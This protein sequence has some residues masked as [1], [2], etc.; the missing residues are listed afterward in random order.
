[1]NKKTRISY[2]ITDDEL[3]RL[4]QKATECGLNLNTYAKQCALNETDTLKL[5]KNAA[6]VMAELYRVTQLTTDMALREYLKACGDC[7]C[8][9]L[10]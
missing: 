1:M 2:Y 5:Q 7:L 4:Q 10:R 8:Q 3:Y 6:F 9:S